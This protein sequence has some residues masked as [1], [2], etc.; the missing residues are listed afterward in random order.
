MDDHD[1]TNSQPHRYVPHGPMFFSMK[2]GGVEYLSGGN[3]HRNPG[4]RR[5]VFHNHEW[6][7]KGVT[8]DG[9]YRLK[10]RAGAFA[11]AGA[12]A[13][14]GVKLVMEYCFGSPIEVVKGIAIDAPL[15][16]PKDYEFLVYLQQGPPGMDRG[17]DLGWDNGNK[18]VVVDNPAYQDVQWKPVLVAGEIENA[19]RNKQSLEEIAALR[20]KSEEALKAA[21]E[22]RRNFAGPFRVWDPKLDIEKRPRIWIGKMEWEGPIVEWPQKGRAAIFFA[23][24]E[25]SDDAYVREIFAKFLPRAIRCP[26]STEE[27][28]RVVAWTL[29]AK[30][31][32]GLD[33][34]A[35]VREGLKNVLCSPAFLYVGSEGGAVAESKT[36]AASQ[37]V[38]SW[39]LANRL[40][41]FLWSTAPDVALYSLA[42][43]N[44]LRDPATLRA[45]VQ[46][47]IEDRKANEFV[48]SFAGQ[49]LGVRNFDNGTPPNR[50][51]YNHYDDPL[52]DS[53]KLEPLE[54]FREVL[55]QN[56]PL[57]SFLDSDFIVV[58][59]RLA[60]HYGVAG[61][62]GDHFRRVPA[63]VD[64]RRGGVLG[65]AGIHTYLA[66]GTR[67]LPVRR[68]TWV[69]DALWNKPVPPPPPNAGDLPPIKDKGLSVRARL[70]QHR[71]SENCASCHVRVDPFGIAL[72]NYD[73]TG[74][75]RDR[76]N[77][78]GMRGND[79]D[80][81]LDVSGALPDGREFKSVQEFKAALLAEK[82]TFARG[83]TEKLLCY[84]LGRPIGYGDHVAVGEITAHAAKNDLRL[85]EII[86]ATVAS[87][88]FQT[89]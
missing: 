77:G 9:W 68:A 86:Q 50:D 83:F 82:E 35:A 79:S 43:K 32:R 5:S 52:R 63:P 60:K 18:D 88:F 10:V 44:A 14:K 6:A 87:R 80:P 66:D 22:N 41:Y 37:P 29:K 56:L 70:E 47:M 30:V 2:N 16:A 40:S 78:E 54:F 48:R 53:S 84:A 24:E 57:T 38:D 64:G 11:G 67:T 12:E 65:M 26:A 89:K 19:I 17:W 1:Q 27:V 21:K 4:N 13:Q 45:E 61:V 42:A 69:L 73:A 36:K 74:L 31:D 72:E 7:K 75:W 34:T 28:E 62:E 49:W 81:A 71:L 85:Q 58:N 39:Q 25:R 15:H 51:F 33:L 55:R 46:R 3:N 76:Q 23:G 20:S 59:E 8:R